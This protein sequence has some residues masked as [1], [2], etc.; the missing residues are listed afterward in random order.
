[1]MTQLFKPIV[2]EFVP[3][4]LKEKISGLGI[5]R[6]TAHTP[7]YTMHKFWARRP[8]KVFR[9]LITRFTEPNDII[10][11][12][13]A[14]GGVT[15]VEGLIA[16][17]RVIAI[18][19]NPLAVRIMRHEVTPLNTRFFREAL[20]KL[21]VAIEPLALKLYSVRCPRCGGRA[22]ATWT[23]YEASSDK[24]IAVFYKCSACRYKGLKQPEPGDLPEPPPLPPFTRVAIPL[25]DKTRDLLKR[26]I[27]YFDQLFTKRNLY[28]VLRLK[29]EIERLDAYGD[30]VKS[31]LLFTLSSTLKWASKMSHRRGNVIEGWAL[32]AYWIYPRYL[33]INVW[34]QFLNRA[35]AVLKGKEFT[36]RYIGS[37][38]REAGSFEELA[39]GATYMVLQADSRKLPLPSRSVDAVITD[40]PY[41]DNVNYAELS[42]YFLWLFGETAPKTEEIIINRTRGFTIYHYE[43]GLEEVFKECYRVL[44]PRGLLIST[45][46]SKDALVVGT[47][48]YSVKRAGFSFAGV[49]LQPYLKAYETTFHALQVD[50]MPYDYI[51]FFY[52]GGNGAPREPPRLNDL[53]EL[54]IEEFK[55]CKQAMCSE[56]EYRMK[57]YP[58]LI[59]VF[60]HADNMSTIM[61]AVRALENIINANIEYFKEVRRKR[62]EE[63]RNKSVERG[64][65]NG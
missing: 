23:E 27:R 7:P 55:A 26:D 41:G 19:L 56:R 24:P 8:W 4:D 3:E 62:I 64:E 50:S 65:E 17:R 10:L 51:F 32:H 63:R 12:P 20:E 43:R 11:D 58:E 60:V 45:F 46:N 40:P 16:R 2:D 25:G 61:Q 18:D 38:A 52:K 5:I 33:E 36:N 13:F 1:M 35:E 48:I 30:V 44:K 53:R 21:S 15:L 34:E 57:V 9:E 29:E 59:K 49:S 39:S 14:G 22:V 54:L 31:F 47:F 28:M 42:D 37:Y 6:T